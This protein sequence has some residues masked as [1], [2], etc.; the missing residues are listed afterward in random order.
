ML[1]ACL[2]KNLTAFILAQRSQYGRADCPWK[3]TN[4]TT[5]PTTNKQKH[6]ITVT[7]TLLPRAPFLKESGSLTSF[8]KVPWGPS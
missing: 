2:H 4:K 1:G 8:G 3:K 7:I 6:N 5:K